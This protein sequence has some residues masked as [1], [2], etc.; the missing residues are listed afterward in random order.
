MVLEELAPNSACKLMAWKWTSERERA[1][2][3]VADDGL[4]DGQI[5]QE[6]GI[7]RKTLERWRKIAEL[8]ARVKSITEAAQKQAL[9]HVIANQ[10]GRI[11]F[12]N[13]MWLGLRRVIDARAIDPAMERAPGGKTGLLVRRLRSIRVPRGFQDAASVAQNRP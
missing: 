1:A 10:Y 8:R 4:S 5:A 11:G 12:L 2:E 7:N 6:L 13:E 9:E 3:L